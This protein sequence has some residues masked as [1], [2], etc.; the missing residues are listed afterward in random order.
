MWVY[1]SDPISVYQR[2]RDWLWAPYKLPV[3]LLEIHGHN[4]HGRNESRLSETKHFHA[5]RGVGRASRS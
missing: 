5:E 3:P 2:I 1:P 4:R